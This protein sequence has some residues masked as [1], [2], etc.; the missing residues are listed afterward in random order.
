MKI[1]IVGAGYVGLV[2]GACFAEMGHH[3]ICLD[4]DEEKIHNLK[5]GVIPIFEPGLEEVVKRNLNAGRLEFSVDYAYGV[6]TSLICF[7]AVPTPSNPDGSANITYVTEAAR[8]IAENM[9]EYKIIVN[10]ST[11]PIGAAKQVSQWIEETLRSRRAIIEYDVVSNPEF[12]KEGDAVNDFM[13]PDRIV[14]GTDHPRV[15]AL[16]QELYAPFNLNH[17]RI[18]IMDTLSAEMTKYASNAMLACRISFMN[19]IAGLCELVGADI[20]K[21]RRGIGSDK[22]IGYAFLYAGVGYGGSCFPKDV[23]ALK[24]TANRLD[25]D[26]KLLDAI[27]DV[28]VR[29]K[30]VIGDKILDYFG[31]VQGKMIA[32]WGLSFKPGTDDMREAPSLI[33]IRTLLEQGAFLKLY[34]PIAMKKAKTILKKSPQILWCKDEFEAAEGADAIALITEW[35]QFRFVDFE[36]IKA[37]MKGKAF[38]YGRNQYHP[39]EMA[40]KGFDY[41]GIGQPIAYAAH[42]ESVNSSSN[43]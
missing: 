18:L 19:E 42:A 21:V 5:N 2:S 23:K 10:K 12:L 30:K 36:R 1:L 28:N 32:I 29:Q 6:T 41:F 16:M 26:T 43:N 15:A 39:E 4:I 40:C 24:A 20:S 11:V 14:I 37:S 8:Q 25:Y 13:K 34:D 17:E 7:I 27:E 33:L 38:F 9:N 35:K 22:R 31:D 3:V